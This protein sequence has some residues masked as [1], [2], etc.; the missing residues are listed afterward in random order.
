MADIDVEDVL[1][2]LTLEEKASLTAGQQGLIL[3]FHD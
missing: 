2:Q 1:A 3:M